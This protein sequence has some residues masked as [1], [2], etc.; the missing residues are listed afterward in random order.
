MTAGIRWVVFDV[1]ET[2]IDETNGWGAWADWL[3]IP[4]LTFCAVLGSLIGAGR[5]WR[6]IF[7]VFRPG[8]DLE[9]A[10]AAGSP[11]G[12]A[13]WFGERDLYP[14]VRAA[15]TVLAGAGYRLGIAANQPVPAKA[16]LEAL[17]LAAEFTLISDIMQCWKPDPAFYH[18][19]AEAA[20]CPPG[21][22]LYVGDRVDNDVIPASSIGMPVAHLRRGPWGWVQ[23][24]WPEAARAAAQIDSLAELPGLLGAG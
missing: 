9:A 18:R 15:F 8:F 4:R 22:I 13:L 21:A 20:A 17:G 3:G 12:E 24:S 5:S 23:R 14:D 2:L 10:I 16:A 11:P 6:D 7:S 19:V 1:G